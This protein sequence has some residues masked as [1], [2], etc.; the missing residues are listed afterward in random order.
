MINNKENQTL[1]V[2][3]FHDIKADQLYKQFGINVL[4]YYFNKF[5][6]I[7][8]MLVYLYNLE[9]FHKNLLLYIAYSLFS[10]NYIT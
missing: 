7:W 1:N 4:K 5:K 10:Q 6:Y 2:V 9:I 3:I 8:L